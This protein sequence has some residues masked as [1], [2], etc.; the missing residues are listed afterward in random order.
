MPTYIYK[1]ADGTEFELIQK[2]TDLPLTVCPETGQPVKRVIVAVAVKFKGHGF[3]SNDL[4]PH[5][6]KYQIH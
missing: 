6:S 4:N 1:R 2:I 3:A 5:K